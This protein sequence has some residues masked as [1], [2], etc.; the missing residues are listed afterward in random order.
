MDLI[1]N[2]YEISKL[3]SST[4]W[5]AIKIGEKIGKAFSTKKSAI[6]YAKKC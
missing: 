3:E 4:G 6:L 1:I 5:C 2:G